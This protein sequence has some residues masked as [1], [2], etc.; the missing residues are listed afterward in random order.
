MK[1]QKGLKYRESRCRNSFVP[2]TLKE[3]FGWRLVNVAEK[4]KSWLANDGSSRQ[5]TKRYCI[6]RRVSPYSRNPIFAL[7]ELIANIFQFLRTLLWILLIPVA[8][9]AILLASEFTGDIFVAFMPFDAMQLL[10]ATLIAFGIVYA[11][12]YLLMFLGWFE[13]KLFGINRKYGTRNYA[14]QSG[15][16]GLKVDIRILQDRWSMWRTGAKR[17]KVFGWKVYDELKVETEAIFTNWAENQRRIA[18]NESRADEF[19]TYA[20]EVI[21]YDMRTG[22][23]HSDLIDYKRKEVEAQMEELDYTVENRTVSSYYTAL[24]RPAGFSKTV[25]LLEKLDYLF[26][27]I[28]NIA[29]IGFILLLVL[30][31]ASFWVYFPLWHTPVAV[32]AAAIVVRTIFAILAFCLRRKDE[33]EAWFEALNL[34][35]GK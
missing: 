13:R 8:V 12:C 2:K 17:A 7:T 4:T 11:G 20:E 26:L 27:L 19:A 35:I 32:F 28:R 5:F 29:L 9:L 18:R 3:A 31:E 14:A 23:D 33:E 25:K 15:S 30:E 16:M 22:M 6:M 10:M 34:P 24:V 21:D 1:K